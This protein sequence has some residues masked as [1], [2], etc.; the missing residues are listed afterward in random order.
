VGGEEV[1]AVK[2][3]MIQWSEEEEGVEKLH[4]LT[5]LVDLYIAK[6]TFPQFPFISSP[7]KLT[8]LMYFLI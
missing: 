2:S 8:W 6:S 4:N 1:K 7:F 3:R 5:S